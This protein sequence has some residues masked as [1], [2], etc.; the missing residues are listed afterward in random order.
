MFFHR[1]STANQQEIRELKRE[2]KA[3][4]EHVD[5]LK[6]QNKR[7]LLEFA[8][9]SEKSRRLYLR[10]TR[11]AKIDSETTSGEVE[12]NGQT[13]QPATSAREVREQINRKLN[14]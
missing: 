4:V 1:L 2:V 8:E 14:L 5:S 9:M 6:S 13:E 11:R 7:D 3:L 10:L 12:A